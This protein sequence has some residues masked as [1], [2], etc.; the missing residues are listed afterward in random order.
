MSNNA[1][2]QMKI[3]AMLGFLGGMGISLS[4]PQSERSRDKLPQYVQD[5][6]IA[7]AQ[8][9]RELKALKKARRQNAL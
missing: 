6:L 4:M 9:R 1:N 5:E 3:A 7:K 2:A 8:A